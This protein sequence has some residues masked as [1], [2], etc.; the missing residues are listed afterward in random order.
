[1]AKYIIIKTRKAGVYF[2]AKKFILNADDFGMT[3]AI[4][5]AVLEG[6][7]NGILKSISIVPNGE[8]FGDACEILSKLE[9]IDAGV[10]LNLTCGKALCGDIDRLCDENRCFNNSF[11]KLL[12]KAYNFKDAEFLPQV[13]REFRRQIETTL[14]KVKVSHIDSHSHI[15]AIPPIFDITCRL[16]KEYG[17]P[18]IRT[19]F[20]K[21]YLIPDIFRYFN[22]NFPKDLFRMLC[23]NFFSVINEN[24]VHKYELTTN[25]Y[26]I[27]ILYRSNMDALAVSYGIKNLNYKNC[28]VECLIHPGRYDDGT[29]D[30][31]FDEYMITRNKKLKERIESL[32]YSITGYS[33]KDEKE[34]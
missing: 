17:I 31:H 12:V 21:P 24:T 1:M 18:Q 7:Q 28:I 33:K 4:N 9:G 25:D 3:K 16:A 19:H 5:R 6:Y 8:F 15:H 10:H 22:K 11:L 29:I 32:G 27:G 23:L 30:N 20:E 2:L 34:A 13:E 14:A 26:I